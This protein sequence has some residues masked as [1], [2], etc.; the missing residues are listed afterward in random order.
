MNGAESLLRTLLDSGIDTCFMNPGTSEM[1][2]VSAA[3]RL[4]EMRCVLG[5]FEGIVSGA[6]DGYS[7]MSGKPAATL[8]HLGP[9]LANALANFHN[10]QRANTPIVNVVG[11]HATYHKQYDAPLASDVAAYAKPVSG[12]IGEITDPNDVPARAREAVLASL[13]PPGQIATLILPADTAWSE[14]IEPGHEN[15]TLPTAKTVDDERVES[16][17]KAISTGEPIVFLLRGAS[18]MAPGLEQ[19]GKIASKINARIFCDTFNERLI[20]QR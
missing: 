13:A 16:I 18:L 4:N 7:R 17:A 19:A 10:A 12:W 1:H 5:L 9:G 2:F 15:L 14:S 20:Y 3:D 8:L 11:D 6:A